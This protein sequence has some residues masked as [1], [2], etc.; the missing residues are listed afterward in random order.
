MSF[1]RSF[2]PVL[3]A[4]ALPWVSLVGPARAGSSVASTS[5]TVVDRSLPL[6]VHP[7][8]FVAQFPIA[9]DFATIGSTFGNHRPHP[10]VVGRG[11]DLYIRYGDGT[12]RNLTR[13]A[14]YGEAN[15]F[16]G[17][18]SIAVRDPH[19]HWSGDR[20]LFSM[21]V[22]STE[23]QFQRLNTFWQIYE[24]SGLGAGDTA[25]ITKVAHQP[26]DFNNISPVYSPD[27]R[28]VFSSDR[29]RNGASHL[30][31][32]HDE[33]ESTATVTGLWSLDPQQG[34]LRLLSHT[35]SGAFSP[36]VDS[37][38]RIVFTRWDHLQ[39]D[40]QAD[41]EGNPYGTF[42]W[43]DESATAPML[44]GHEVFPEPREAVPAA[45]TTGHTLNHFFPWEIRPDGTGEETLNHIGRHELH[46]YFNTALDND[47]NLVEFIS[48]VSGRVNGNDIENFFQIAEDPQTPGTYLGVDAPEFKTH[49][50]GRIV[51]LPLPV[52][53]APDQVSVSYLTHPATRDVVPDG[54]PAPSGHSGLYREPLP[55]SDGT[56]LAVHTAE[57]RQAENE[58][59]RS[60]PDPR[61]DFRIKELVRNGPYFEAGAPIT[62]GAG[63]VRSLQY[64]DPDVLVSYNGPLWELSPVEVRA[65]PRPPVLAPVLSAPEAQIFAQEGVDPAEF[66]AFL[67]D[68]GLALL[69]SRDVTVRDAMDRQQPFNL[70]IAGTGTQTTGAGGAMY[71]VRYMQFFQ[72][73]QVRGI[74]G[75]DGPRPGRRVL[76]RAMHDP[77]AVNPP[78]SNTAPE[79]AVRL[80]DDGSMAAMVTTRRALTWQMTAEDGTPVVRERYWLTFQPGE[81]R[82]CASCHG[83]SSQSQAGQ[84]E[85]QNPPEALRTLLRFWQAER[86]GL[87]FKDGFETGTVARWS[88]ATLSRSSATR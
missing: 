34:E 69:V 7:V 51:S 86:Q 85:P 50:A 54:E 52:G 74:G 15:V 75:M 55:M 68:R 60:Q 38:G 82:V 78:V 67:K 70:R 13:E 45:H 48:S 53:Q 1:L 6:P 66:Q 61:Y 77:V 24:V 44:E 65:R 18:D 10:S 37:F 43:S 16:Q 9:Q 36:M 73:D 19:V 23:A 59:T 21:V 25:V 49:A 62:P 14:G 41:V 81:I 72:G 2:G 76:A 58:G 39:Q 28:I 35:P 20:A 64:W 87:L 80:A 3:C 56:L 88:A 26:A 22:G 71:D 5:A 31:P 46:D 29:P 79:A 40:Q 27:G 83:L 17:E 47:P 33:Y 11:G 30:Y 63:I 32:Q 42:D 8:L 4:M 84:G 57:V 12:L